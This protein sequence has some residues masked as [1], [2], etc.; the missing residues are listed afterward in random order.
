MISFAC[1]ALPLAEASDDATL[2]RVHARR[3]CVCGCVS[4]HV[5]AQ[6]HV[7]TRARACLVSVRLCFWHGACVDVLAP[8]LE[9]S[10]LL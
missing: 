5:R 1:C 2:L 7:H 9:C 6:V 3:A 4:V 8:E 10:I